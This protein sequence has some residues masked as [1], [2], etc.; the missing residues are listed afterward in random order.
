MSQAVTF[1]QVGGDVSVSPSGG[2]NKNTH[3]GSWV[4][5]FNLCGGPCPLGSRLDGIPPP[6]CLP[7][8]C[9]LLPRREEPDRGSL[10]RRAFEILIL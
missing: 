3:G 8:D 2:Q 5:L 1:A 7:L 6:C 10:S 4:Y 9:E